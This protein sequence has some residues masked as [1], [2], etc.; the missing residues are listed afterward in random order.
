MKAGLRW[1]LVAA[2]A[3]LAAFAGY[4]IGNYQQQPTNPQ[5]EDVQHLLAMPVW[6]LNGKPASLND[7]HRG[8]QVI[9]LWAT[10]CPPCRA[11]MPAFSRISRQFSGKD[12]QFIG[13]AV[14]DPARVLDFLRDTPVSYPILTA[15]PD[16]VAYSA[17]L[18]N[19]AGGLPFTVILDG[20]G[21][22]LAHKLGQWKEAELEAELTRLLPPQ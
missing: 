18:G 17:P 15:T 13:V 12:V 16:A 1:A 6:D 3:L 7:G 14:D 19:Q 9:N 2:A 4:R 21:R 8:I 5:G 20:Q 11:E 22:Y 10:W